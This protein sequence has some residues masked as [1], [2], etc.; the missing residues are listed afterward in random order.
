MVDHAKFYKETTSERADFP[1]QMLMSV[2]A[3][4]EGQ[5]LTIFILYIICPLFLGFKR[6][7]AQCVQTMNA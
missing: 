7:Q 5:M 6:G 2:T 1:F 3:E 4:N